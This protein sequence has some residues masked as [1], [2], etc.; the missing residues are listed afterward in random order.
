[1]QVKVQALHIVG[2][3]DVLRVVAEKYHV[4]KKSLMLANHK[5]QDI[6]VRGEQLAIPL[7]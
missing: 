7:K 6:T 2:P 3:G 4:S 5:D 1:M